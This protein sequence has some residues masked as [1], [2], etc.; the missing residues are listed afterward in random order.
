MRPELL[1][2]LQAISEGVQLLRAG[3]G[4]NPNHKGSGPGGGQFTSIGSGGSGGKKSASR[5]RRKARLKREAKAMRREHKGQRKA[6]LSDQ[7][8]EWARLHR[9]HKSERAGHSK[10]VSGERSKLLATQHE[11][12]KSLVEG[13]KADPA[14]AKRVGAQGIREELKGLRTDQ[15]KAR[16]ALV[17]DHA[18]RLSDIKEKH[19]KELAD[20][21][22][23]HRE[24]R[25]DVRADQKAEKREFIKELKGPKRALLS[26]FATG[27]RGDGGALGCDLSTLETVERDRTSLARPAQKRF[28]KHRTHKASS[29]EAIL[30]H[31][32]RQRGWTKLYGEDGLTGRQHLNLLDDVRQYSRLYL[33]H[34]AESFF[35]RYGVEDGDNAES[36]SGD[37]YNGI[38]RSGN[39]ITS[40]DLR[41][42]G[43]LSVNR[44]LASRATGALSRFFDRAK[45]FIREVIVA[46][47]MALKG[48]EP[49]SAAEQAAIEFRTRQ[50]HAYLD[51]FQREV[52]LNPPR[53]IAD[54]SSL[55]VIVTPEPMTAP[56]F[57]AR[58]ESYGDAVWQS[59]QDSNRSHA[60]AAGY[61]E[62]RR[63]LGDALHCE[64]CPPLAALGWQPIGTL[65]MIGDTECGGHCHCHFEYRGVSQKA[66]PV[67]NKRLRP[68]QAK[69]SEPPA[70]EP[71]KIEPIPAKE[72]PR[73]IKMKPAPK[74]GEPYPKGGEYPPARPDPTIQEL[75]DASGSPHGVDY[76]EEI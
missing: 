55:T 68:P 25:K 8:R 40:D 43:S 15:Q 5:K 54:L 61:G 46:G 13:Y 1:T 3:H 50:Q 45:G 9:E 57:I 2:A 44:G 14:E 47:S 58:L 41:L 7:R 53:E 33:R 34:E 56:Q 10:V 67:P 52:T 26:G 65:P 11:D 76:Y 19:A 23:E 22:T 64:D 21:K 63:V 49:L 30:R 35:D 71:A 27:D 66:T 20:L 24:Y 42:A 17:A 62:E 6:L 4:G 16:K 69:T 12:R 31:V 38:V 72:G 36:R 74:I 37:R 75:I 18:D 51:N 29:A 32:L 73:K 48:D 59:G 70:P 28:S 39:E 60:K